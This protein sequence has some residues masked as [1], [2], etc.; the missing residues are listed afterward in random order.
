MKTSF[1]LIMPFV[2]LETVAQTANLQTVTSLPSQLAESSGL[3]VTDASTFWSHG[4]S[5]NPPALYQ[6]D[7]N[8]NVLRTVS[9]LNSSNADWE[10]LARDDEGNIYIGDFGNNGNARQN[11]VIYKIQNP[12]LSAS[13]SL[14]AQAIHFNYPDQSAFPPPAPQMNFD[15]EAMIWHN[16][17]LYLFSKNRTNPFSGFTRRYR[18]PSSPGTFVAELLDSFYTGAGPDFLW[19]ITAADISPGGKKLIL[20]SHDKMWLFS[21]FEGND[22]FSGDVQQIG[23]GSFSQKEAVC[24]LNENEIY[25]TDELLAGIGGKLYS[26]NLSA[27]ETQPV[28]DLGNDTVVMSQVFMLDA[29]SGF[30]SYQW[31]TGDTTQTIVVTVDGMYSVVVT[32]AAGCTASDTITVAFDFS[33]SV[34]ERQDDFFVQVSPNPFSE[35]AEI[36]VRVSEKGTLEIVNAMGEI[37]AQENLSEGL[38]IITFRESLAGGVYFLK[39]ESGKENFT[40][41][42]VRS[43]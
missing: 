29:D 32:S 41:K 7:S 4:D 16:D 5:G 13:D 6:I 23:L 1:S 19:W 37:M 40:K 12:D 31:S 21:C 38:N 34:I 27:F 9:I 24:F 33:N 30:S 42:L 11:L 10:D 14:P 20:L 25:I 2:C 35:S 43:F 26:V 28:V 15:M 39:V 18:L 22:F 8:G 17:S 3:E 36:K